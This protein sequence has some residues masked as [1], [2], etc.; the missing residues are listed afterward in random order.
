MAGRPQAPRQISNVVIPAAMLAAV[1]LSPR[2]I[3]GKNER[4]AAV[5]TMAR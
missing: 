3:Y 4:Q 1:D 5:A 2:E